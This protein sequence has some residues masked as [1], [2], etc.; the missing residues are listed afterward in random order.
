MVDIHSV[1][2]PVFVL[3]VATVA[4]VVTEKLGEILGFT[5]GFGPSEVGGLPRRCRLCFL[6][7]RCRLNGIAFFVQLLFNLFL[8]LFLDSLLD[9][10]GSDVESGLLFLVLEA[11]N[12][13]NFSNVALNGKELVHESEL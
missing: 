8:D 7:G 1:C 12:A 9:H 4:H 2:L 5:I 6:L 10:V 13:D 11:N 3:K